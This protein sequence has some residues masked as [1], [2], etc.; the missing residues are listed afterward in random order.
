M[1]DAIGNVRTRDA[2]SPRKRCRAS[3]TALP[4]D[5]VL[6]IVARSDAATLLRCAACCKP[7]RRDILS[8]AF[9]HRICHGPGAV[10]PPRLLAFLQSYDIF[11][12]PAG[13]S[14]PPPLPPFVL[15]HPATPAA[16]RLSDK[17]IAP[18]VSR[19]SAAG[20]VGGL[21]SLYDPVTSRG[22]LV[23]LR[24][25]DHAGVPQESGIC[26]YDPMI[27]GRTFLPDP[28]EMASF[29]PD[30]GFSTYA[31]LTASDGISCSFLLL[32]VDFKLLMY[33]AR[34]IMVRTF[35]SGAGEWSPITSAASDRLSHCYYLHPDCAAVVLGGGVVHWVMQGGRRYRFHVLTYNV[36]TAAVG[37]VDLPAM[38]LLPESYGHWSDANLRLAASPD[39]SRLTLLVRDRLTVS[40]WRQ[41]PAGGAGGGWAKHAVIDTEATLRSLLPELPVTS[42]QHNAIWFT[43]VGE[44]SGVVLFH[45]MDDAEERLVALDIET[46]EMH[47]VCRHGNPRVQAFPFEIDLE[48]R[49][50]AMKTF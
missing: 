16:A 6:E 36:G 9:I 12:H 43:S 50:S 31:L 25:R 29:S 38:D 35:S 26:V 10:V 46:K 42:W 3:S 18:F 27:G 30:D 5:L 14:P 47:R 13:D 37:L 44:R 48:S 1:S 20:G 41:L 45:L 40:V 39:G 17:H 24:R 4:S 2:M 7:L 49:L 34:T 23:V 8:P 32:A 19:A 21:L 15:A 28:P 11:F 33:P 22:G